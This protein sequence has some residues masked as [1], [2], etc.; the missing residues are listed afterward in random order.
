MILLTVTPVI[1]WVF[2]YWVSVKL[3]VVTANVVPE[4]VE[5]NVIVLAPELI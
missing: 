4:G 2:R 3:Y 5:P 1:V